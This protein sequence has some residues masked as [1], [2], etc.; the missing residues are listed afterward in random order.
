MEGEWSYINTIT[1]P[2]SS[3]QVRFNNAVQ[4]NVTKLW[5]SRTTATNADATNMLTSIMAGN[6]L[7]IEDRDEASKW[8]AYSVTGAAIPQAT[9]FEY[10][11]VWVRGGSDLPQQRVIIDVRASG[12][13]KDIIPQAYPSDTAAGTFLGLTTRQYY[14][15][16]ALQGLMANPAAYNMIGSGIVNMCFSTAD[17]MIEYETR[18]SA[19]ERPPAAGEPRR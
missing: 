10:P 7:H 17:R 11:V 18:E 4:A 16:Q 9:Y 15:G 13:E 6:E 12:A 5:I 8:Q 2:P 19:G 3:G 1:A 14:A